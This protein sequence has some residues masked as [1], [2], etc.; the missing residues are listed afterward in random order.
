MTLSAL[1]R[2]VGAFAGVIAIALAIGCGGSQE[3]DLT[4]EQAREIDRLKSLGYLGGVAAGPPGRGV[5]V[6]EPDL[7]YQ[8]LNLYNAG[9]APEATLIGM[10]GEVLHQWRLP[11]EE[12][13]PDPGP[14]AMPPNSAHWRRVYPYPNGDLLAIFEGRALIKIDVDSNLLWAVENGAHHEVTVAGNGEIWVLTRTAHMVP[15][16]NADHPI[17]ED[18]ITVLDS[19]GNERRSTSVLDAVR[20]SD[21]PRL[22]RSSPMRGDILHTNTLRLLEGTDPDLPVF[23]AGHV[24]TSFRKIDASAVIDVETNR[25]VWALPGMTRGQ[26]DPRLLANGNLLIFDNQRAPDPGSRVIEVDPQTREIVWQ[27]PREGIGPYSKCCGTAQRL[28]NG[29]TLITYTGPGR[30]IEVTPEGEIVWEFENPHRFGADD[31]TM[32]ELMEED[33]PIAQLMELRRLPPDFGRGWLGR[34]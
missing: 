25:V 17:L 7:A 8:G 14:D 23:R 29:N 30:A 10:D 6:H 26:H 4:D 15:E 22:L 11:Y 9:H 20:L 18:F 27:Y 34:Q 33:D 16:V 21:F 31:E 13:F 32:A 3:E 19:D 12:A 24:L 1:P 28:A 5:V 2:T